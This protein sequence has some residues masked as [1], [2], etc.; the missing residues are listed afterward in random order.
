MRSRPEVAKTSAPIRRPVERRGEV[1]IRA[2]TRT[3]SSS[4]PS[5]K[6]ALVHPLLAQRLASKEETM[7]RRH[8]CTGIWLLGSTCLALCAAGCGGEADQD[9][10]LDQTEVATKGPVGGGT[11]QRW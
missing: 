8:N 2:I 5:A 9:E 4:D 1:G 10:A 3:A 6:G 11:C 7:D